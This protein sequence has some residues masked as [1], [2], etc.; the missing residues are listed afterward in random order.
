MGAADPD[1]K[2]PAAEAAWVADRLHAETLL[3][4]GSG[5]YPHTEYP[6]QVNPRLVEFCREVATGA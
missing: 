3:V 1:F 5:H 4:P 6:D 2:D